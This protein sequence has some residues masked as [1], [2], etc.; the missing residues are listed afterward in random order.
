MTLRDSD[1]V[2]ISANCC[3]SLS[4]VGVGTDEMPVAILGGPESA[5]VGIDDK[6]CIWELR[7]HI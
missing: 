4:C 7:K 6:T 5:T 2:S 3:L 1:S